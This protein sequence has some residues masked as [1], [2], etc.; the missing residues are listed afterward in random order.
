MTGR[1]V[2]KA[3]QMVTADLSQT[4]EPRRRLAGPAD[5]RRTLAAVEELRREIEHL[6][7][8]LRHEVDGLDAA[9]E[10]SL[11]L[12]REAAL[13]IDEMIEGPSRSEIEADY[14]ADGESYFEREHERDAE[15][16]RWDR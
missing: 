16:R 15:M 11:D 12:M 9:D 13:V 6:H 2:V 7:L 8:S 3:G 1:L 10:P 14:E 5:L 4:T